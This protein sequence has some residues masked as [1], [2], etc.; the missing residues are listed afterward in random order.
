L[1]GLWHN[2]PPDRAAQV[3]AAF[4]PHFL[5]NRPVARFERSQNVVATQPE[6]HQVSPAVSLFQKAH[7]RMTTLQRIDEQVN[8]LTDQ[9]RKIQE[10]LRTIQQ[11]INEEFDRV[12]RQSGAGMP[13]RVLSR[14]A[15]SARDPTG[16][17][18]LGVA[19]PISADVDVEVIS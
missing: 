9:R 6:V 15:D 19:E 8:A 2:R 18:H 5:A 1:P 12:T 17:G 14:I 16:N 11:L 3:F 4:R 7:G 13:N 10:E